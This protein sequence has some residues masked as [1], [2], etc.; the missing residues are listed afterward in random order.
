MAE[1]IE[2]LRKKV[3]SFITMHALLRK[4]KKK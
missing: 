1:E 2:F 3:W 4:L